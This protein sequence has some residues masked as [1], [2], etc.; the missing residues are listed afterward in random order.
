MGK[1]LFFSDTH[2]KETYISD[3]LRSDHF[4]KVNTVQFAKD[5]DENL[6]FWLGELRKIIEI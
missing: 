3:P 2:D 5:L 1:N 4:A 6:M